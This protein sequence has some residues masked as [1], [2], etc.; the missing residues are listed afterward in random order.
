MAKKAKR[1]GEKAVKEAEE[2]I[3]EAI[4]EGAE[5]KEVEAEKLVPKSTFDKESWKP[6]TKLG[7]RVKND[8]ER[9]I[10]QVLDSGKIIM[11]SEIVDALVPNLEMDLILIGQ[12]KG[13]FG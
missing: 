3:I 10:N 12:A 1:K 11:E 6:K 8:E 13:K 9:D 2:E 7:E 4:V 5:E